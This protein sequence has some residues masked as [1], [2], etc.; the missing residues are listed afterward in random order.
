MAKVITLPA[1]K[2]RLVQPQPAVG[3]LMASFTRIFRAELQ[4]AGFIGN[5][6][7]EEAPKRAAND[8]CS[9]APTR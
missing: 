1:R 5:A 4:A 9:P 2:L 6:N 7:Q 8:S 3:G